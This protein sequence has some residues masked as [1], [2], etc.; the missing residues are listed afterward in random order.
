[1]EYRGLVLKDDKG[2]KIA[3]YEVGKPGGRKVPGTYLY[4]REKLETAR[5]NGRINDETYRVNVGLVNQTRHER[6][7]E[8][9]DYLENEET[10]ERLLSDIKHTSPEEERIIKEIIL[11]VLEEK[12]KSYNLAIKTLKRQ[13][14]CIK[15]LAA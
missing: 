5:N 9:P 8:I 2:R 1:M 4:V 11:P 14:K 3:V 12:L 10:L 7:A 13:A 15:R 6:V